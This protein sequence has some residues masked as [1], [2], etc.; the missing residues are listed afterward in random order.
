MCEAHVYMVKGDKEDMVLEN[1]DQIQVNEDEIRMI[2]I[3]GEQ[4][5]VRARIKSYSNSESKILI[6]AIE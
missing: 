5:I 6:E 2:S 4:Q 1:V 3:F